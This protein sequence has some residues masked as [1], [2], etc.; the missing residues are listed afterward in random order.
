MACPQNETQV[1]RRSYPAMGIA[2]DLGKNAHFICVPHWLKSST[3]S[4]K[5]IQI[6]YGNAPIKQLCKLRHVLR[7]RGTVKQCPQNQWIRTNLNFQ[8]LSKLTKHTKGE[9][10]HQKP[11]ENSREFDW[12][13]AE[14]PT[15]KQT[16]SNTKEQRNGGP[17]RDTTKT[18]KTK[19]RERNMK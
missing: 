5:T 17:I 18:A 11:H 14:N 6:R 2:V 15:G 8:A 9:I 1:W 4:N 16:K 13:T 3:V 12:K 7:G 10:N 19:P